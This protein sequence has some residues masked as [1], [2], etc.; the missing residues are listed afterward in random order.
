LA[1]DGNSVVVVD[2]GPI[3]GG[4]TGR[5]T[6]HLSTSLDDG[7]REYERLH[8]AEGARRAAESA[9]AAVDRIEHIV[10]ELDVDCDFARVDG[11]LFLAPGDTAQTIEEELKAAHRAGLTDVERLA[12]APLDVFDTGL[13]LRFPGQ[14]QFHPMKYLAGL[15]NGIAHRGGRI[16]CRTRA[17]QVKGGAPGTVETENGHTIRA[18]AIVTATNSPVSDYLAVHSKQ[19]PYRTYAI[20]LRVPRNLIPRALYWDTADPYHYVRVHTA[21]QPGAGS[22]V[23]IV[24]GE[25]HRTGEETQPHHRFARL[26]EWARGRFP[27]VQSV[28]YRWSGQ[29]MEPVHGLAFLGRDPEAGENTFVITGDSG[30]GMVNGTIGAIL[31]TDLIMGRHNAWTE[32]YD[33]SRKTLRALKRLI[34]NNADVARHY[35]EYLTPGEVEA[36]EQ[37]PLGSGAVVRRGMKKIAVY[38]DEQGNATRL[39]AVCT[40]LQCIVHW[41]ATENSW[42][43]PCHGSRFDRNGKVLNGPAR[44]DLPPAV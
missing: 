20:G 27:V 1:K 42:D 26:E 6:A 16:H 28:E 41:N 15:V 4:E 29:V 11:Y 2:D 14:G 35:G 32:L 43:C 19:A 12:R 18:G 22:D 40:H 30:D 8:G 7:Y 13:C 33:P 36:E 23:L 24:G 21:T 34:S 9:A 5:T 31:V 44:K 25:D 17:R 10:G 3:G 37:I 39:S 38:R